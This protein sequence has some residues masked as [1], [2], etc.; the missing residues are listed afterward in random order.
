MTADIAGSKIKDSSFANVC[1][2][3]LLDYSQVKI[4]SKLVGSEERIETEG[5][6]LRSLWLRS[7]M[8]GM[9]GDVEMLQSSVQVWNER[10]STRGGILQFSSPC[11]R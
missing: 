3:H 11:P 7:L 9:K 5:Q 1:A 2:S 6:I 8:G 10:F 4:A